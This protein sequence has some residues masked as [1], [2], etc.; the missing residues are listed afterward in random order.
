[1]FV[2]RKEAN[3]SIH[4]LNVRGKVVQ[5]LSEEERLISTV[6]QAG[7]QARCE[8]YLPENCTLASCK[9]E[10]CADGFVLIT[11]QLRFDAG[12]LEESFINHA[13]VFPLDVVHEIIKLKNSRSDWYDFIDFSCVD[14]LANYDMMKLMEVNVKD[15]GCVT[16]ETL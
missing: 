12:T 1:M 9:F 13:A 11:L 3:R 2:F 6:I 15:I 8:K 5:A 4:S 14:D 10:G 16:F 7:L